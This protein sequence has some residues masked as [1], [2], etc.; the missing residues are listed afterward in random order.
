MNS[1][2]SPTPT[3]NPAP[4]LTLSNNYTTG[5]KNP[6]NPGNC[7]YN[8][9]IVLMWLIEPTVI[10]VE[11]FIGLLSRAMFYVLFVISADYIYMNIHLWSFIFIIIG[12]L[13]W[14]IHWIIIQKKIWKIKKRMYE[15]WKKEMEMNH[16]KKIINHYKKRF[17][18]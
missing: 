4:S 16:K 13:I 17:T 2:I 5:M 8:L 3:I 18:T 1:S 6:C 7:F 11:Y 14:L 10:F 15:C 9:C 12:V